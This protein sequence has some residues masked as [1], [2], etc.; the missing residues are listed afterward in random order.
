MCMGRR[1]T[2]QS[3]GMGNVGGQTVFDCAQSM[4]FFALCLCR[5]Y[6]KQLTKKKVVRKQTNIVNHWKRTGVCFF[7]KARQ[8]PIHPVEAKQ[9]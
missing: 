6:R 8:R 9:G 1:S 4:H 7:Y 5:A 2:C 3:V